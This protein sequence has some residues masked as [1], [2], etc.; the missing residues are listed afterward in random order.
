MIA[1]G[2]GVAA[3]PR[4][5]PARLGARQRRAGVPPG[6]SATSSRCATRSTARGRCWRSSSARVPQRAAARCATRSRSCRSPTR[7]RSGGAP[8]GGRR[9]AQATRA[10]D[11]AA[12]A[13]RR[14]AG[15]A[16]G[17]GRPSGP[18]SGAAAAEP[19]APG[20]A[21]VAAAGCGCRRER[22]AHARPA[23]GLREPRSCAA[24]TIDC[25]RVCAG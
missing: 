18:G 1:A 7:A 20:P 13:A 9:R 16:G 14:A 8:G 5:A 19:A 21:R 4:R 15:G 23:I 11:D 2:G 10:A 3:E 22:A 24:G 17:G 25:A 12:A 6:T